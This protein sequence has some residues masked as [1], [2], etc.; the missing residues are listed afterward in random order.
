MRLFIGIDIPDAM[1]RAAHSA[2]LE[3][4][5]DR[6]KVVDVSEMH[7][8]THFI[9]EVE[10]KKSNDIMNLLSELRF[11]PFDASLAGLRFFP[12]IA[13][14]AVDSGREQMFQLHAEIGRRLDSG[15]IWYDRKRFVPH[16]TL[17]RLKG[18]MGKVEMTSLESQYSSLSLG[19]FTVSSVS[20]KQSIPSS[21][22][23]RHVELYKAEL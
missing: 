10:A 13:Y 18:E 3:I 15:G 16:L 22:G 7:I 9:G 4:L 21:S 12:G 8:T 19:T 1:K 5:G 17:A 20:L 11:G 14:A 23:A 6:A 2:A